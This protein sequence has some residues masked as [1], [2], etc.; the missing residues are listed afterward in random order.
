MAS[1]SVHIG[2]VLLAAA[3]AVATVASA[4]ATQSQIERGKY[5]VTVGGCSDCHTPGTFFGH[6]DMSKYLGGSD[7]G[8]A[9]PGLG[10]FPGR[11]LTPD[12]QTGLGSW[13]TAQIIKAFTTGVRPDGRT[14][15]PVMPYA[16][17]SH[18]THE[19]ALA[20]AAYLKSL[21]PVTNAVAGPFGPN[22]KPTIFVFDVL[23]AD[24]YNG[25]PVPPPP[26]K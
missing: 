19:D 16:A 18:L 4:H 15:A 24:V 12:K 22:N 7:V 20:I 25:L 13:T 3:V 1:L 14:L 26:P 9:I 5:L 23:P 17:L 11:N 8:F 6:P 2:R 21:K 10:V